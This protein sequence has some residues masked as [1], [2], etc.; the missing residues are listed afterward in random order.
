V[1]TYIERI[2]TLHDHDVSIFGCFIFGLDHDRPDVFEQTRSFIEEQIDVPQI[3][4]LTPFPGTALYRRLR[5]EGRLLHEDWSQYDITHA[6][7]RPIGMSPEEL[8]AG[9]FELCRRVY[10]FPA[11]LK[12]ALRHASRRTASFSHPRMTFGSRI[13]SVLA[14]NVIYGQ[15]PKIGRPRRSWLEELD[16]KQI[17]WRPW[18]WSWPSLAFD[19]DLILPAQWSQVV[20]RP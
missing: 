7:F 17:Q 14:P 19:L 16:L 3:S 20:P 18:R 9:Y 1:E 11:L 8:D 15:L 12:R 4:M 13:S 6:V 10:A 5:R 2:Q